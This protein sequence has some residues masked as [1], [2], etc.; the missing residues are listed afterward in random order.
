M[1]VK[2]SGMDEGGNAAH[3]VAVIAATMVVY[4][5]LILYHISSYDYNLSSMLRIGKHTPFFTPSALEPGLVVFHDPES[6]G[7]GYDGQFY[8]YMVKDLLMGEEGKQNPFRF[9]RI[10]YPLAAYVL[11]FGRPQWLP[12]SMVVVNLLAIALSGLLLWKIIGETT[13]GAEYLFFYT[14]NIGFLIAVFYDV[15]TPLC[16]GLITA[17]FY[18][19]ERGRLWAAAAMLA[20]SLLTQENGAAVVASFCV[21]LAWRRNWRGAIIVSSSV[22]P[23]LLW[24]AILWRRY[25]DFPLWM[26]GHHFTL[27]FVGMVSQLAAFNLSGDMMADLRHLSVY[28]FMFFVVLLLIVSAMGLKRRPADLVFILFVHAVVG[29]CFNREQIWS[30][31][32]TSPARALAG[33]FP[34]LVVYYSR[35]RSRRMS[36]LMLLCALLAAMGVVRILLMPS[37]PFYVT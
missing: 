37:H 28:P 6:G 4:S 9:Q 20:L 24:Q 21:L 13:L 7:D 15:A 30:S 10:L 17:S 23:W 14:L 8:Y 1:T 31:T 5:I 35:E 33:V 11:A 19:Y 12:P 27:P 29:I 25:G 26:S 18:F 22:V 34:F 32:V 16:V 36:L 2:S 3:A